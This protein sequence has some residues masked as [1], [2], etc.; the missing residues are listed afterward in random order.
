MVTEAKW[1]LATTVGLLPDIQAAVQT[2][3]MAGHRHS[4]KIADATN[5][6]PERAA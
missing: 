4:R 2:Q 3:A 1:K 6:F 5:H